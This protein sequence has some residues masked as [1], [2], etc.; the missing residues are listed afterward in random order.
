MYTKLP[1]LL[2]IGWLREK[3][4]NV[5]LRRRAC[6]KSVK[7]SL[8][9]RGGCVSDLILSFSYLFFAILLGLSPFVFL[10]L[11]QFFLFLDDLLEFFLAFWSSSC[12]SWGFGF[13]IQTL[14]FLLSMDSS[15]GR[16]RNQVSSSLV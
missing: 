13:K 7:G 12:A 11:L 4:D 2:L 8:F 6:I 3:H 16:L 14:C 1:K 15:K 9:Q 10:L 5:Y